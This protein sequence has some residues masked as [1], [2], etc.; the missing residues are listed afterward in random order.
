MGPASGLSD[1]PLGVEDALTGPLG[2]GQR[3]KGQIPPREQA[4]LF[5]GPK[6]TGSIPWESQPCSTTLPPGPLQGR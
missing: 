6:S 3:E 4:H 1:A 2:A 5:K